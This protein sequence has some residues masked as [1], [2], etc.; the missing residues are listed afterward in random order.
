MD[1]KEKTFTKNT[2]KILEYLLW[3]EYQRQKKIKREGAILNYYDWCEV[4]VG[5]REFKAQSSE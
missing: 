1:S 2:K 3:Q 5:L 4:I